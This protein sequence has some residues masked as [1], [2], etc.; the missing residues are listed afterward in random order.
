M[1]ISMRAGG[2]RITKRAARLG[3]MRSKVQTMGNAL[4]ARRYTRARVACL[5]MTASFGWTA[6][7]HA[8]VRPYV[9]DSDTDLL[10]SFE[11]PI[12]SISAPG[13][14]FYVV[15]ES[16]NQLDLR[17]SGSSSPFLG[18]P[19]PVGLGRALTATD[20]FRSFR[21]YTSD[22]T[23]ASLIAV[24]EF[25]AEAWV[26]NVTPDAGGQATVFTVHTS[27]SV[28]G[29]P[30]SFDELVQLQ[31]IEESPSGETRL[32]LLYFSS[33]GAEQVFSD[34]LP[35]LLPDVWYHVAVT[36][37]GNALG[38]DDGVARFYLDAET[39]AGS[40]PLRPG[41]LLTT[42]SGLADVTPFDGA[43]NGDILIGYTLLGST[44]ALGGE[45]DE[46][47]YSSTVRTEFELAFVPPAHVPGLGLVGGALAL[48]AAGG[49]GAR[50]RA[51]AR[52]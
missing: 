32:R 18:T 48:L 47:R 37:E 12:G 29:P 21:G 19:G 36:Y 28:A 23:D 22:V 17:N 13:D 3:A 14:P 26:R 9:A 30:T 10:Y 6:A 20:A 50:S 49:L 25:T 45:L 43:A 1:R 46:F 42:V 35:T 24:D 44:R 16:T 2:R 51:V 52:A 27:D 11:E 8:E 40:D 31:F 39:D 5:V 41:T 7:A 15:D 4:L 33:G 38:L 34:A